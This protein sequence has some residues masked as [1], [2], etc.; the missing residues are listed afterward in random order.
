MA[1]VR[2]L[3]SDVE[4]AIAFYTR[5][6]GFVLRQQFGP[7]MAILR[8]DDLTFWLAGPTASAARPM[9]DGRTPEP[10]GWNRIVLEVE[11]LAALIVRM[12]EAGVPFRNEI[13][14]G[15][16]G[17]QILCE[18]PSGNVVELFEARA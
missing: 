10:G 8:R 15:P 11:D 17:R 3:V 16:G 4:L 18:D 13:V 12:R 7:A 5:H 9:P 1:T 2:Y 14:D 6:L